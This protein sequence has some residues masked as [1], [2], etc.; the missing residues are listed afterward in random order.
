MTFKCK[1]HY[2]EWIF[3]YA[4]EVS[5]TSYY[6]NRLGLHSLT[7]ILIFKIFNCFFFI[8]HYRTKAVVCHN[9]LKTKCK[10]HYSEWIFLYAYEV[11]ITSYYL[12]RLGLH[13]LTV[14]LI[15]TIF[16]CF[17]FITHY[18]TKAVGCHNI[19]KTAVQC[20]AVK[21]NMV[22]CFCSDS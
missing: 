6:L 14:I 8:T 3:L 22:I 11:S 9:I 18:R 17:F 5:V 1:L 10:L 20:P 12:N 19:L 7:V 13:S 2:S 16:N 21:L 4:Y 15:F